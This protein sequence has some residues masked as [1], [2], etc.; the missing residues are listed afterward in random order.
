MVNISNRQLTPMESQV[1]NKGLGYV[2]IYSSN[3]LELDV[4]LQKFFRLLRLRAFFEDLESPPTIGPT[5]G[6]PLGV[7]LSSCRKQSKWQPPTTFHTVEA[8][9]KL[10]ERDVSRIKWHLPHTYGRQNNFTRSEREALQNLEADTS[11]I[12]KPADKGGATVILDRSQYQNMVH[13]LLSDETVYEKVPCDPGNS[14]KAELDALVE[15]AFSDGILDTRTRD[16]LI[17]EFPITPLFYALPKIHKNLSHPPGRPIVAGTESVFQPAAVFLDKILQP[18]V[19]KTQSFLLDTGDFLNRIKDLTQLPSNTWLCSMDVNSLY[20]SIPHRE[21]IEVIRQ[22]LAEM[23]LPEGLCTLLL[24]LLRLI[25]TKNFFCYENQFFIQKQGTAMGSNVAPSYANLFMDHFEKTYVYTHPMY[26]QHVPIWL[27]FIDD[28]FF[29]WQGEEVDLFSFKEQ[30]DEALPTISFTIEH[31]KRS[32]HFLDVQIELVEGNI[33]T[34]VYCKPTDRNTYLHSTSFHP[35]PMKKGLPYSQ[36]IRLRRIISS[37]EQF[38]RRSEDMVRDFVERGYSEDAVVRA[39]NMA[40]QKERSEL[41]RFKPKNAS[42][43]IPCV[44]TFSTESPQVRS[45]IRKHWP[46][47]SCD[48]RLEKLFHNPPVFAF[49]RSRS[50]RDTL[51]HA[52]TSLKEQ[53]KGNSWLNTQPLPKGMFAC[54]RCAQCSFVQK[55]SSLAHPQTGRRIEIR[56]FFNCSSANVIYVIICPCGKIYVGQT[57]REVRVRICEH[58]SSIRRGD[59][60]SPV[61]RHFMEEGHNISQLKF[62]VI[63]QVR[64][65]RRG[66]DPKKALLRRELQWMYKLDSK[67]PKGMNEESDLT[68]FF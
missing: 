8:F 5:M 65:P 45:I 38:K 29:I 53:R 10:V 68:V 63:D 56:G 17:T 54:G 6:L 4:Q 1:L 34:D 39:R 25:L 40:L 35:P 47:L 26:Q 12:I 16:F 49:K 43:R 64:P 62:M 60:M 67:A 24:E 66:G 7:D 27:R 48:P 11:I 9:I 22:N 44:L 14:I 30:L 50:L 23:E 18:K 61:A 41:L 58:R 13:Q 19:I 2:P 52:D 59:V 51:I 3:K 32:V 46:V 21:G 55:G 36:F 20:T 57:G 37:D 31:S 28:V 15:Q 42:H 33:K